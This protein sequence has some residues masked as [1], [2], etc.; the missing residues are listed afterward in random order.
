MFIKNLYLPLFL[1]AFSF[2]MIQCTTSSTPDDVPT[3]DVENLD[4]L[5]LDNSFTTTVVAKFTQ[6]VP[7]TTLSQATYENMY[8]RVALTT[9]K[10][11]GTLVNYYVEAKEGPE[12]LSYFL[13]LN[14]EL[15]DGTYMKTG[16]LLAG[17]EG[18]MTVDQARRGRP[19]PH[20]SCRGSICN[21]CIYQYDLNG[22]ID[23]ACSAGINDCYKYYPDEDPT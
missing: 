19:V 9:Q 11:N 22:N 4:L 14:G 16:F 5:G 18:G 23:C 3:I 8:Q 10:L 6:G 1:A 15:S 12:G 7:T 2:L 20:W 21:N 13:I 17:N